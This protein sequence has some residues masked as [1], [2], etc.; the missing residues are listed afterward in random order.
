[1]V[2]DCLAGTRSA[3][4]SLSLPLTRGFNSPLEFDGNVS[5]SELVAIAMV[6][7]S[8]FFTRIE[9]FGVESHSVGFSSGFGV[10]DLDL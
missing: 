5:S 6:M 10:L 9:R 1:M 2:S 4:C 8:G 7:D 3:L